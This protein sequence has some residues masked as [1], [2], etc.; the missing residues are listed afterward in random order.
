MFTINARTLDG[1]WKPVLGALQGR[2]CKHHYHEWGSEHQNEV[3]C[4]FVLGCDDCSETLAILSADRVAGL[5]NAA[6]TPATSVE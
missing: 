6:R 5:L 2:S 4:L 3:K 1:R